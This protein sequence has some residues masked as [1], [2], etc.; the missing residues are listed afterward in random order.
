MD[1]HFTPDRPLPSF[2][3]RLAT[4][5]SVLPQDDFARLVGE[6]EEL[7]ETERSYLPAH[8]K[9]GTVA[10]ETL[11][12]KA[13]GLVTLYRS[14]GMRSL[15]SDLVGLKVEPTPLNDQ[16][17]CSVLFYE[18]PGDHI[19]W[20]YDHNFY[21]GR[22]FTVLVPMI[23]R[24]R[25]PNGLSQARLIVRQNRRGRVIVTPPNAMIIFEGAK[26]RH[27]VTPIGE[28]ERR[29]IWSMTFCTD[30]RNSVV[31]GVTRRVKDTAFFG[32]RALWT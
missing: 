30:P 8:K 10:Y 24:G 21:K 2:A 9:G 32:L 14:S 28:G 22:H 16:S 27:K 31:Q 29:V 6:I 1:P 25:E 12:R 5:D 13:P 17:S 18:K 7:V 3:Q 23:N 15:I 26:V 19:G 4:L 11:E 20:H